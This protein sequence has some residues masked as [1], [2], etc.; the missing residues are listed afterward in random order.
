MSSKNQGTS[1]KIR[2]GVEKFYI[3]KLPRSVLHRRATWIQ[4]SELSNRM[5]FSVAETSV[6][7]RV[8]EDYTSSS[9]GQDYA[10]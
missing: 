7:T 8:E 1:S 9:G 6:T 4:R 5:R 2:V 3:P 10:T